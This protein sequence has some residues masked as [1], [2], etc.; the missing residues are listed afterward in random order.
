MCA[1]IYANIH[2]DV[3]MRHIYIVRFWRQLK[4]KRQEKASLNSADE[5]VNFKQQGTNICPCGKESL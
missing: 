5:T 4:D 3:S 2:I 1:I